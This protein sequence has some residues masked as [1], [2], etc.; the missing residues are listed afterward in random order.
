MMRPIDVDWMSTNRLLQNKARRELEVRGKSYTDLYFFSIHVLHA[1][2]SNRD[3]LGYIFTLCNNEV[4]IIN[5][6]EH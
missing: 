6:Q 1:F 2:K 3:A 5:Y 4:L